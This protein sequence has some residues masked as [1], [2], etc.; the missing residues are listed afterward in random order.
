MSYTGR[1]SAEHLL[2]N[3]LGWSRLTSHQIFEIKTK[4]M[5]T[6]GGPEDEGRRWASYPIPGPSEAG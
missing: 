6:V 3:L 4:E 5:K 1:T 2:E